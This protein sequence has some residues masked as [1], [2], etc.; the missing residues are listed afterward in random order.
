MKLLIEH[1]KCNREALLKYSDLIGSANHSVNLGSARESLISNFLKQNLPEFISYH[2]GEI[3]DKY[4]NRSGQIDIVLHP[5]TSPK[6]NLHNSISIFPAEAVLS[7]IEIKSNLTT[8]KTTGSLKEAL[9]SCK[10]LKELKISRSI[11]DDSPIVDINKVSFIIFAFKGPTLE[12]LKKHLSNVSNNQ[13]LPDLILILDRGYCLV[14]NK[15][16]YKNQ[17]SIDA[18]DI[19]EDEEKI[20]I[21]LFNYILRVVEYW[22]AYPSKHTMPIDDYINNIEN[23]DSFFS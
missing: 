18:F 2:S 7:A 6:I 11:S 15:S 9:E 19:E 8:G 5:I 14:K 16:F 10:K 20:L 3:F 12:T 22:F 4:D 23:I 21:H 17:N 13:D 1:L